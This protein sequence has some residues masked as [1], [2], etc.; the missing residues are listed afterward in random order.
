MESP[1]RIAIWLQ[2]LAIN[3]NE[4]INESI[5]DVSEL[6]ETLPPRKDQESPAAP[7]TP[8]RRRSHTEVS[9]SP[10]TT[11]FSIGSIFDTSIRQPPHRSD[12]PGVDQQTYGNKSDSDDTSI[13]REDQEE[14]K[15]SP[16]K[17]TALQIE[18]DICLS[19]AANDNPITTPLSD[20]DNH[21]APRTRRVALTSCLQC[22]LAYLPCS[23]TLP[24]CS[25]CIRNA[26][27]PCLL[28]RLPFL[29]EQ[30]LPAARS[31]VGR[32]A[33]VKMPGESEDAWVV[34][35]EEEGRLMAVWRERVDRGNWV[36]PVWGEVDGGMGKRQSVESEG[37]RMVDMCVE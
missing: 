15:D 25:R 33:L 8:P 24:A 4:N 22:L 19:D 11:S 30:V 1:N 37:F 17:S 13:T 12:S 16:R 7:R 28:H 20:A 36:L 23:R 10:T 21:E 35:N 27:S 3:T 2:D 9:F 34:R 26:R 31:A 5:L 18:N 14:V 32:S 29:N 6:S